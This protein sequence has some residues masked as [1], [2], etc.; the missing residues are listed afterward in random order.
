MNHLAWEY[1]FADV[2]DG[3]S[4]SALGAAGWEAVGLT[5]DDV[6][7]K[8]P[9]LDFRE[10]VTIDQRRRYFGYWGLDVPGETAQ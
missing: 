8:R 9:A 5:Q 3:E 1:R 6:L 4:L 2:R 7:L 10:Q